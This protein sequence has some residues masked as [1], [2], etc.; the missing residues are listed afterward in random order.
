MNVVVYTTPTCSWCRVV[1]D[2]LKSNNIAYVEHDVTKD[3]KAAAEMINKSGQRGVPVIDI[4]GD[5]IVGFD[6]ASIDR[7]LGL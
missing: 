7:V 2:Y 5:I 6:Q 4:D 1:K 3:D